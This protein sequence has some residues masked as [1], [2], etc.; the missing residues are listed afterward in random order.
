MDTNT[1]ELIR[2]R[3]YAI[4]EQAG[5]PDG[6]DLEFWE[7]A[8]HQLAAEEGRPSVESSSSRSRKQKQ[9]LGAPMEQQ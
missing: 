3:A 7:Q 5:M 6:R 1:E 2:R 9:S 8:A 4:W